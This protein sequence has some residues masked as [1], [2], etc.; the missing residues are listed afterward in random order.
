[1]AT[2][3]FTAVVWKATTKVG[4]AVAVTA[5]GNRIFVVAKYEQPGNYLGQF[6]DNVKPL[7]TS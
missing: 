2:G 1:M 6:E 4:C 3:H 5:D 7:K